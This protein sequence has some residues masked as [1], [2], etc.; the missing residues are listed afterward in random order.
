LVSSAEPENAVSEQ[1]SALPDSS[2]AASSRKAS[3]KTSS[4]VSNDKGESFKQTSSESSEI[5]FVP[6]EQDYADDCVLVLIKHEY[7][8]PIKEWKPEDFSDV[9]ICEIIAH[10]YPI[11]GINLETWCQPL[12]IDINTHGKDKV[13]KAIE[14]LKKYEIV[15]YAGPNNYEYPEN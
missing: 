7:S 14:Q 13:L 12:R 6:S 1:S 10:K 8:L 2:A 9:D 5:H 3:L 11:N 15:Q 4:R